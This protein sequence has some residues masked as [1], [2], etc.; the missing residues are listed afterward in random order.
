MS[1]PP[2]RNHYL[3]KLELRSKE[4]CHTHQNMEE[5]DK[6]TTT[7]SDPSSPLPLHEILNLGPASLKKSTSSQ[8]YARSLFGNLSMLRSQRSSFWSDNLEY[9]GPC[10]RLIQERECV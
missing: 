10:S 7:L 3:N 5:F 1:H 6:I 2:I 9:G 4:K 8:L